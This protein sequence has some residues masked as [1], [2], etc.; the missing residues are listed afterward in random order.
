[1]KGEITPRGVVAKKKYKPVAKKVKPLNNITRQY[2]II[3]EIK[4]GSIRKD[5]ELAR[6]PPKFNRWGDIWQKGKNGRKES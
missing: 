4:R 2:R 5:A 3:R 6:V 1:M